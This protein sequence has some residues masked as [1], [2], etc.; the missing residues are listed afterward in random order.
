M[1]SPVADFRQDAKHSIGVLDAAARPLFAQGI[2]EILSTAPD[3]DVVIL[4]AVLCKVRL[5]EMGSATKVGDIFAIKCKYI[6]SYLGHSVRVGFA[7]SAAQAGT[8]GW[9]IRAQTGHASDAML[10]RYTRDDELFVDNAAGCC[11]D[12]M[13][14]PLCD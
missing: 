1:R 10:S 13:T 11:C 5:I 12:T 4:Q 3:Y 2:F 14:T 9:K 7:T 8:Q 6:T